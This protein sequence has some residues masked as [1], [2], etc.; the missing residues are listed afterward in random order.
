[1]YETPTCTVIP[2][3]AEYLLLT[4]SPVARPGGGGETGHKGSVSVGEFEDGGSE[5][6]EDED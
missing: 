3:A 5:E 4:K 2:L 6:I 1:M